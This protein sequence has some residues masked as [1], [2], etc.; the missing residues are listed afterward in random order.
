MF[1]NKSKAKVKPRR[2]VP[3]GP[4]PVGAQGKKPAETPRLVKPASGKDKQAAE[5]SEVRS[6]SNTS[7]LNPHLFFEGD[8]KFSG[9][10]LIDCDF[11]G[12]VET[13]DTL[14]V[15]VAGNVQAE[16]SAGV[17]EVSGAVH[18]NI[19]ASKSVKVFSGGE[20]H[21]NIETPMISM[22][23]GVVFEGNCTRPGAARPVSETLPQAP[24]ADAAR[25]KIVVSE[26]ELADM[27]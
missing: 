3:V 19:R 2:P 1:S 6:P 25:K 14:V 17:V 12:T 5:A 13:D 26:N 7:S 27:R 16:V 23:E 11:R 15:G 10:V 8:L 9:T 18:G 21:G 4:V 20:V 22:E 24:S